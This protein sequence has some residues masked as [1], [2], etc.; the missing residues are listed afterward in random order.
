[1]KEHDDKLISGLTARKYLNC[2]K[3]KF[4]KLVEQGV[5]LAHRDGEMRW[6]V[7]KDSVLRYIRQRQATG[8]TRL[9]TNNSHYDS[10]RKGIF[11]SDRGQLAGFFILLRTKLNVVLSPVC[12][13]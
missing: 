12:H 1:M 6:R 9:I 7:S 8:G 10:D 13:S 3:G 4:E 2:S 11:V 5:I